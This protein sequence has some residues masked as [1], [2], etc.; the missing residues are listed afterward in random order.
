[1]HRTSGIA[2]SWSARNPDALTRAFQNANV[3]ITAGVAGG[4]HCDAETVVA[5]ATR[6]AGRSRT[7][8]SCHAR[9]RPRHVKGRIRTAASPTTGPAAPA[10]APRSGGAAL[11]DSGV[12]GLGRGGQGRRDSTRDFC[13]RPA[14][15]PARVDPPPTD[16]E[17]ARHYLWRFWRHLSRAGRVTI[18]DRSWYQAGCWSSAS[19]ASRQRPNKEAPIPRNRS[20]RRASSS[21]PA[22][23]S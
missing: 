7:L 6:G 18:F 21:A 2:A 16:E 8:D 14:Q 12:R 23:S 20:I 19:M 1:M 15:L 3:I 17:R 13:A 22:S 9:H 10:A 5:E 11:G 4:A